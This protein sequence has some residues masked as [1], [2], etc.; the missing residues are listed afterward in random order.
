MGRH[1]GRIGK[2]TVT[3]G[4]LVT[5]QQTTALTTIQQLDPLYVDVSQSS[6]EL[7]KLKKPYLTVS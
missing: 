7:L 4:A 6:S 3:E 2:S 5:A 1:V